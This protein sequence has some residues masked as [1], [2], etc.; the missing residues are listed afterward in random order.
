MDAIFGAT[1]TGVFTVIAAI[2]ATRRRQG[3]DAQ[4]G[5]MTSKRSSG[6]VT[7]PR[8][9]ATEKAAPGRAQP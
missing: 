7:S 3:D 2:I 4:C 9:K 1:I 8:G 5:D 6:R